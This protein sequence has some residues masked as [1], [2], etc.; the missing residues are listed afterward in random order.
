MWLLLLRLLLL[1]LRLL[2]LLLLRWLLLLLL[3]LRLL[4]RVCCCGF[5]AAAVAAA[6]AVCCLLLRAASVSLWT[7][8]VLFLFSFALHVFAFENACASCNICWHWM[9]CYQRYVLSGVF[10]RQ[11]PHNGAL[12]SFIHFSN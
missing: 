12:L 5:A 7:F 1:R 8:Q 4:L 3:L 2:L 11:E 9:H 6:V 10:L